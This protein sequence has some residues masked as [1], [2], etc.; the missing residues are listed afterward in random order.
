[1]YGVNIQSRN[2]NTIKKNSGTSVDAGKEVGPEIKAHKNSVD[3]IFRG[4]NAG[5]NDNTEIYDKSFADVA[6]C[7]YFLTALTNQNSSVKK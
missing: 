2:I 6:D 7:R 5:Q 4:Q 1:V 3:V